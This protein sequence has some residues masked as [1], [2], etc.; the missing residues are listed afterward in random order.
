[1]RR[2]LLDTKFWIQMENDMDDFK[3]FHT[4]VSDSEGIEVLFCFGNLVDLVKTP[5]QDRLA[6]MIAET[7]DTYLPPLPADG[8]KYP[9]SKDPVD[10]IPDKSLR[11]DVREATQDSHEIETLQTIFRTSDWTPGSEYEKSV[12]QYRQ[13]TENYDFKYLLYLAFSDDVE[14][15]EEPGEKVLQQHEI[16]VIEYVKKIIYAH[17]IALMAPN[18]T[19]DTNDIADMA[20][21]VASIVT[22]CDHV[23]L[24]EKWANVEIIEKVIG[25]L[26]RDQ[27]ITIY[28]EFDDFLQALEP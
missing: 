14:D 18:E 21:C 4:A 7:V 8:S 11:Q 16:D 9:T 15:G 23:L 25:D 10:M 19:V 3:R 27:S 2:V 22:E 20:I 12:N 13:V 26:E 17:R 5:E 6:K 28:T 1:M 24:E